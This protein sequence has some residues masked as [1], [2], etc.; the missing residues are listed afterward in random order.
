MI[1]IH[2]HP[3]FN[4]LHDFILS[5][6]K[7]QYSKDYIF[8]NHRNL[9]TK[10]E[11]KGKYY[12]VKKYKRPTIANCMIYTWFRKNKARRAYENAIKL[13][14]KGIATAKPVA[15][16]T[17]TKFGFFHTG[18]LITEYLPYIRLDVAYL[19]LQNHQERYRLEHDF[20]MFTLHLHHLKILQQ[21]NNPGNILV[22]KEGMIYRF[23]LV[24]VNR[25]K[26]GKAIDIRKS[27][28]SFD[29]LGIDLKVIEEVIPI[30]IQEKKYAEEDCLFYLLRHQRIRKRQH[31]L[32]S[33]LKQ[34]IG[35]TGA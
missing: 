34:I 16:I 6:P 17:I 29:Q 28:V 13:L 10:T 3:D 35:I 18:Y 21:D 26:F 14:E 9:V 15:Y 25:I 1:R 33:S 27:M 31:Q 11:Y 5:I 2:L 24:D 7:N 22:H 19:Q 8:C 23:A 12:V 20:V 30:Y 4:D 32:K